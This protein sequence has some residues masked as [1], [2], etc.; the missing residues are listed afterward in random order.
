MKTYVITG[1]TGN[2]G[3]IVAT[4]LLAKGEKVR[5]VGRSSEK[6][7]EF[8]QKGAEIAVGDVKNANFVKETFSDADAVLCMIP[9][10]PHSTDP[11][12]EQNIITQNYVDAVTSNGIKYVILIS[13]VG[14]HLR[15]SAGMVDGLGHLEERFS[16]L[17]NINILNLRPT[18]FMENIF[19]QIATI[20]QF[21]IAGS[22][23]K[24]D[25]L[26]PAV[27]TKDIATVVVKRITTLNFSGN[28]IEYVLGQRDI[29]YNEISQVIGKAIGKPDLKYKQF[30]YEDAK[31]GMVSSGF[32]SEKVAELM[33]KLM[34]GMNNGTVLNAHKRTPEN[35]TPTSIEEFAQ[36]FAY[37]FSM[38]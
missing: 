15:T 37:V 34:E 7:Q 18:Y 17:K 32:C 19:A 21:G 4:E 2:I 8:K 11:R 30:S 6:L 16:E 23:L 9:G 28:T 26:F 38:K 35:T 36:T 12:N 1:A 13:S 31:K 24:G 5:V 22:P 27:A 29:N 10:D 25:L 33:N 20:K 3:K 14:A